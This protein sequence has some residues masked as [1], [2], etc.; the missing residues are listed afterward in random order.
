[1]T[2]GLPLILTLLGVGFNFI[3][4]NYLGCFVKSQLLIFEDIYDFVIFLSVL[5]NIISFG[6]TWKKISDL[7]ADST[8]TKALKEVTFRMVYYPIVQTLCWTFIWVTLFTA[9]GSDQADP[10]D[11]FPLLVDSLTSP[12]LGLGMFIVFLIQQP[13]AR[14]Q[15]PF[16]KPSKGYS[17]SFQ[18]LIIVAS[19]NIKYL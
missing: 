13:L 1:M 6:M 8:A 2:I 4:A 14:E 3:S 9:S 17:S 7:G 10:E 16:C 19:N 5:F 18:A 11:F 15:L 12:M